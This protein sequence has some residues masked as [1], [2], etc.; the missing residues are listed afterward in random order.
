MA[1]NEGL[2]YG[3]LHLIGGQSWSITEESYNHTV[4]QMDEVNRWVEEDKKDEPWSE[5]ALPHP[6]VFV[7]LNCLDGNPLHIDLTKVIGLDLST[8]QTRMTHARYTALMQR[9][10]EELE[11]I[12]K[13]EQKST[14]QGPHIV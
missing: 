4:E 3:R 5:D 9:E 14:S 13:Q 2:R 6:P 11:H 1:T 12:V 10:W 7:H 8:P